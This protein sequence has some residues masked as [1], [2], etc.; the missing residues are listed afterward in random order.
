MSGGGQDRVERRFQVVRDI[1]C[2]HDLAGLVPDRVR[3]EWSHPGECDIYD[4]EV[5]PVLKVLPKADNE[6]HLK[7]L[8]VDV[9][10]AMLGDSCRDTTGWDSLAR[11]LW[12][13]SRQQNW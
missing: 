3:A 8:V 13:V 11:E 12:S 5:G 7:E 2:R 1:L 10:V 9:F 6:R 4:P